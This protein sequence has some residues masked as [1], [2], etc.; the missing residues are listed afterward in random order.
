MLVLLGENHLRRGRE[1]LVY[2]HE[3]RTEPGHG[4]ASGA[5]GKWI[6]EPGR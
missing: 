4:T 1:Y 3:E 2:Y 6:A 5:S